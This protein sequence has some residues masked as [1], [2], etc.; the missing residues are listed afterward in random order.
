MK[1]DFKLTINQTLHFIRCIPSWTRHIGF[2]IKPEAATKNIKR[3][4]VAGSGLTQEELDLKSYQD[5]IDVSSV[6]QCGR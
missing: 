1:Y 2:K 5:I 4:S 3:A 6:E